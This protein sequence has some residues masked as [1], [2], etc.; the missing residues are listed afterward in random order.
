MNALLLRIASEKRALVL[1][2]AIGLVLNVLAYFI[3]VR[4]LALLSA[5][6]ADRAIAVQNN[7][8][9]AEQEAA[10]ARALVSGKADA[11]QEL[12]SFYQKVL[13]A[14]QTEARR[15]TYASLPALA[16][17]TGVRYE[18][19][20]TAIDEKERDTQLGHMTIRMRL[21]GEYANL[22]QFVY[23]LERAPEFIIIDDVTLTELSEEEALSLNVNMST[24]Y[25]LDG[26]GR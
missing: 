23:A 6:A 5:G 14:S 25:R 4:P 13:P 19:R 17:E 18:Q 2:L 20:S 12:V 21:Q 8:R 3:V 1:P 9:A 22:R 16:E 15:M 24:Y 11:D 7:L 10:T 26:N